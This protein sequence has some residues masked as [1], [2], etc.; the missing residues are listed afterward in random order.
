[1]QKDQNM[2]NAG[3]CCKYILAYKKKNTQLFQKKNSREM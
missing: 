3:I 1:M 2:T